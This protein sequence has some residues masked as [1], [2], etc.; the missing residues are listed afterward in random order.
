MPPRTN[1][2]DDERTFVLAQRVARLATANERGQPSVL[3]V[4][5]AYDGSRFYTP[6]DEKPKRVSP[7]ELRRVRDIQANPSVSLVIDQYDDEWS[8]LRYVRVRAHAELVAPE[9]NGHAEA[10]RL[11]R[12]RYVQYRAMALEER[13]IIALTP[14]SVISWSPPLAGSAPT[15]S[16]WT[17]PG[18]GL[19]FVPLARGRRSVRAFED[20]P[21]PREALETMLEAARW[22]PSPHG[23]QPWRFAVL[24]STEARARLAGAM[25]AEWQRTLEM[26]GQASETIAVRLAKSRER[27]RTA[28]ALILA[29]LYLE[30]LDQY[31]DPDRQRAE[32]IMAIQSLGAAVQNMLLAAYALGLDTGWMCAPLFCPDT[33]RA[34]LD[35]DATLIPHALIPVGFA[36]RDPQRRPHR[37]AHEL[38]IRWQ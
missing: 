35:F 28:P 15:T 1:L 31:P 20:R 23:R 36:A 19:D 8:H 12:E 18:R 5:Y 38:V 27:I 6:L 11:L 7:T 21:V 37:P 22:A 3:P 16:L 32:E 29:C 30:E 17:Q 25:G 33:V 34:A 13:P 9:A 24:T 4:C 26:D 2:T 10:L 14:E